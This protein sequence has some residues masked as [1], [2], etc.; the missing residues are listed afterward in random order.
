MNLR[1]SLTIIF[2]PDEQV[3]LEISTYQPEILYFQFM[4]LSKEKGLSEFAFARPA[5]CLA[6]LFFHRMIEFR[7]RKT[8]RREVKL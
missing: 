8:V 7:Q 3:A 1:A 5:L 4:L 6:F 2:P